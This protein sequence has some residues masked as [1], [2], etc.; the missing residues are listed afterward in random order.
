MAVVID[1]TSGITTPNIIASLL[2][3]TGYTVSTLPTAGTVGRRTHVTNALT[4]VFGSTVVGGGAVLVPVF[5]TGTN[6]IVG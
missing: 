4:P 3:T 5:D 1:G 6:W 2:T